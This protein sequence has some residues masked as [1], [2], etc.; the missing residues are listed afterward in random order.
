MKQPV[1]VVVVVERNIIKMQQGSHAGSAPVGGTGN[2]EDADT[3]MGEIGENS[4]QNRFDTRVQFE[5]PF[6]GDATTPESIKAIRY[7][8]VSTLM[9]VKQA[10]PAH[11]ERIHFITNKGDTISYLLHERNP[12]EFKTSTEWF[13][14]NG[15][16][17]CFFNLQSPVML[18]VL[19]SSIL[20]WLKEQKAYIKIHLYEH[21]TP[22]SFF[23]FI[24]QLLG[25]VVDF[26]WLTKALQLN[27]GAALSERCDTN[28]YF[29]AEY[30]ITEDFPFPLTAT[31]GK[32][33][34]TH[35]RKT[36]QAKVVKLEC[37]SEHRKLYTL[38][39]HEVV[40][41]LFNQPIGSKE[42]ITTFVD[43]G[44]LG[45]NSR[46]M[47]W[48]GV[49]FHNDWKR[50]IVTFE[51]QG[52]SPKT[53]QYIRST[54]QSAT[55]ICDILPTAQVE[56]YGKWTA[57]VP[58]SKYLA[59]TS[60]LDAHLLE[61]VQ[62]L[63]PDHFAPI[64]ELNIPVARRENHRAL[65]AANSDRVNAWAQPP[66]VPQQKNPPKRTSMSQKPTQI[67]Q[68]SPAAP[69]PDSKYDE[70][71]NLITELRNQVRSQK[72]ELDSVKATHERHE[73]QLD[74]LEDIRINKTEILTGMEQTLTA[75]TTMIETV[76]RCTTFAESTKTLLED[77]AALNK[78]LEGYSATITSLSNLTTDTSI[79]Q[80]ACSVRLDS[81]DE[82]DDRLT[83]LE[84]MKPIDSDFAALTSV[85]IL[86]LRKENTTTKQSVANL[87]TAFTTQNTQLAT[88]QHGVAEVFCFLQMC[89]PN[90]KQSDLP[91]HP[92]PA[93][94]ELEEDSDEDVTMDELRR[95][96][97]PSS[98]LQSPDQEATRHHNLLTQT[99]P[100]GRTA[101]STN[102]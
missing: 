50:T 88:L 28:K 13:H 73:A 87:R 3:H 89:F 98:D 86:E 34:T 20:P 81:I 92:T 41:N 18:K 75:R 26:P 49:N 40:S 37:P 15:K 47:M 79:L 77:T 72:A 12:D 91:I 29:T 7:S 76:E 44:D 6:S 24:P 48:S 94:T 95:N 17:Y 56:T 69:I 2:G 22:M 57:V 71:M 11:S 9:K 30:G 53:M 93:L 62:N 101:A 52:I 31:H 33:I 99:P 14:L 27:L 23:A 64:S 90:V 10:L 4:G 19:K 16:I 25:D 66:S 78:K 58:K 102:E 83:R 55:S 1:V 65:M 67:L 21:D 46:Y 8:I 35:S 84:K 96:K 74:E 38:L 51:I 43:Y 80:Q 45:A 68:R 100:A 39:F 59:A 42:K 85:S 82:I 61:T 70:L 54:I 97:R 32:V 36:V 63:N 60:W 5:F